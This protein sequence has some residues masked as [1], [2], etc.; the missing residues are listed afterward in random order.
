MFDRHTQLSGG[1]DMSLLISDEKLIKMVSE[2]KIIRNGK[3][4]NCKG[5]K[6]DLTLS[7][8][9]LK[10]KSKRPLNYN[11]LSVEEKQKFA[12]IKPGEVIYVLAEET[13][14]MPQNIYAQL[15]PKRNMGELGINVT[16]ALIID[17]EYE[18]VL[19]F[20]LYN[21][22]SV[23]FH[24]TPGKTFASAI[25]YTLN[26]NEIVNYSSGKH[27]K[28]IEDFSQELINTIE[29]YEPVGFQNLAE[30]M[31]DVENSVSEIKEQLYNN[32]RWAKDIKKILDQVTD[33]NQANTSNINRIQENIS[34]LNKALEAEVDLRKEENI[35][36][37]NNLEAL[38]NDFDR[39]LIAADRKGKFFSGLVGFLIFLLGSGATIFMGWITGFFNK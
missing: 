22:S 26:D 21:Y 2:E 31:N 36:S 14:C 27:P 28:K 7:N 35:T 18:G 5:M 12:V 20:G 11:E 4:G 38:K 10:A 34:A 32:D 15:T 17:P 29:K 23:D 24:F 37:K 13:V 19:V 30:R 25:F 3:I 39:Q 16:C 8:R 9:F 33:Q 6:Y 1:N